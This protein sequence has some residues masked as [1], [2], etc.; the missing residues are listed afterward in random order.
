MPIHASPNFRFTIKKIIGPFAYF[1]RW[2]V[3]LSAVG[4]G[5]RKRHLS[6]HQRTQTTILVPNMFRQTH[7]PVP[8]SKFW[9]AWL[10]WS[11]HGQVIINQFW[12]FGA[13][14]KQRVQFST[15]YKTYSNIATICSEFYPLWPAI[16][17]KLH[18][19]HSTQ[20]VNLQLIN[21]CWTAKD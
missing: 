18:P 11:F 6:F 5:W 17:F 20:T 8:Y 7:S 12:T 21:E 9:N 2:G 3:T 4:C 16:M 15:K 13:G 14:L 10:G 1:W 19:G